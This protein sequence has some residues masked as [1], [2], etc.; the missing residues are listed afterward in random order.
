MQDM[1]DKDVEILFRESRVSDHGSAPRFDSD[2]DAARSRLALGGKTS[3]NYAIAAACIIA[4]VLA[5]AVAVRVAGRRSTI[6]QQS[7]RGPDL[8]QG[9][10]RRPPAPIDD[11]TAVHSPLVTGNSDRVSAIG[12]IET[13]KRRV[14]RQYVKH[15]ADDERE[16]LSG[17]RSPTEFL[18]RSPADDLLKMVPNIQDSMV[19]IDGR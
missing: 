3:F 16:L 2:W 11:T 10:Q 6:P 18:L 15:A 17:W 9:A 13:P 5:A 4:I 14:R 19:R 7:A 12:G 1:E 8:D